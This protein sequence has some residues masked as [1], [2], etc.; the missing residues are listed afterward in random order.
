MIYLFDG[1][2]FQ[3]ALTLFI[4]YLV[5]QTHDT[6]NRNRLD[7]NTEYYQNLDSFS[8]IKSTLYHTMDFDFHFSDEIC[9]RKLAHN[10]ETK[11]K[12]IAGGSKW[13]HQN[14]QS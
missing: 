4:C 3:N 5:S 1:N 2:R 13:N 8:A 9:L 10:M 12:M 7:W 11:D 14:Y 6:R